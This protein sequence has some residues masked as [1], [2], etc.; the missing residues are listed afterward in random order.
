MAT[1]KRKKPAPSPKAQPAQTTARTRPAQTTDYR[2]SYVRLRTQ[3]DALEIGALR[4][5]MEGED[6]AEM[7]R[8]AAELEA[9]IMPV[10]AGLKR[11]LTQVCPDGII[12]CGGCCVPYPCPRD[13]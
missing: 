2:R 9:M 8:R 11:G 5:F 10:I 4:Y 13:V 1:T 3:L 7:E 6:A 12:N